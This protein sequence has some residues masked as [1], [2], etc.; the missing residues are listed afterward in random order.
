MPLTIRRM[1]ALVINDETLEL[2]LLHGW[3]MSSHIWH[4]WLPSLRRYAH[5]TLIDLP[6]YGGSKPISKLSLDDL[7]PQYLE[8]LPSK[9]IYL[10]YSLGG[11][12]ATQIAYRFPERVSVLI[13]LA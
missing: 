1:Q 4:D 7:L 6:G 11:M 9:A 10:G 12:L 2:V 8:H 13:S 3:G 5:V